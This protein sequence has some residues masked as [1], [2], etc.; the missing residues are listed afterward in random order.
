MLTINRG[1]LPFAGN[2]IWDE[3]ERDKLIGFI[4]KYPGGYLFGSSAQ[5]AALVLD[6]GGSN[7]Y[8]V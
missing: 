5:F 7:P 3:A 6:R 2:K 4:R 1:T 8:H